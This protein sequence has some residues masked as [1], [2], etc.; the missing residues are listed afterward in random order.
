[1]ATDP[2]HVIQAALMVV[3]G[4]VAGLVALRL[5]AK[6]RRA[7]EEAVLRE[8]VTNLF[9]PYVSP[10]VVDRL[11]VSPSEFTDDIR[12][13]CVMFLD[14]RNFTETRATAH[15]RQWSS[16]SIATLHS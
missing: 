10:S 9:D 8:R 11:S 6:F 7:V 12:E 14:I 1:M 13:I 4:V 5:R 15:P 16:S 2:N 3:A